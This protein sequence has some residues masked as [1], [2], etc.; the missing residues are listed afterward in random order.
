MR[1]R[2]AFALAISITLAL[3]A[4]PPA[5]APAPDSATVWRRLLTQAGCPG[6]R[7]DALAVRI[8]HHA[9]RP[10]APGSRDLVLASQVVHLVRAN[11]GLALRSD[12]LDA[13]IAMLVGD[14][15]TRDGRA[16]GAPPIDGDRAG[17]PADPPPFT[18]T[19]ARALLSE[20]LPTAARR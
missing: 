3:G 2:T 13:I 6:D 15:R 8:A 4:G 16:A 20:W 5:T 10:P 1:A 18:T 14:G 7:A 19:Q 9:G 17:Q 11:H 12:Q